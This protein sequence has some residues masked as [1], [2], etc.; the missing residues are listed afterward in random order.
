MLSVLKH[1]MEIKVKWVW[2]CTLYSQ[3]SGGCRSLV[4]R[5]RLLMGM[6]VLGGV[7]PE[8]GSV[9][10]LPELGLETSPDCVLPLDLVIHQ[11]CLSIQKASNT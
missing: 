10:L 5:V 9:T 1:R 8:G 4:Y 7:H 6:R 11:E 3:H 2:W